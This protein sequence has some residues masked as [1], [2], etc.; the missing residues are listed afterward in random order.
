MIVRNNQVNLQF[1]SAFSASIE[2]GR[3]YRPTVGLHVKYLATQFSYLLF[4]GNRWSF[5]PASLR[6]VTQ[7]A[8]HT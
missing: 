8:L 5:W 6:Y 4:A 2:N 1:A 3:E 7:A